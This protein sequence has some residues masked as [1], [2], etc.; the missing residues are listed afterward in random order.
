MPMIKEDKQQKLIRVIPQILTEAN[1]FDC[2]ASTR[3]AGQF[4]DAISVPI[5]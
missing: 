1:M 4:N 2:F 3:T 5:R